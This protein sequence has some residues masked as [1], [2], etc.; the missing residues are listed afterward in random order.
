MDEKRAETPNHS[1]E[2]DVQYVE[3]VERACINA[4]GQSVLVNRSLR[5]KLDLVVLPLLALGLLLAY[6]VGW[7][8]SLFIHEL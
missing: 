2:S 8:H 1:T 6:M 5:L 3:T 4:Q 7:E